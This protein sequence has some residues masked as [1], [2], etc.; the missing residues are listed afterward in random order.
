MSRT[1]VDRRMEA[2][3]FYLEGVGFRGI[4]RLTGI[5]NVTVMR[6]VRALGEKIHEEKTISEQTVA[7]MELDE[8]WHFIAKKNKNVGCGWRMTVMRDESV[9]SNLVAV[10]ILPQKDCGNSLICLI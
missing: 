1:P 8:L 9:P 4:E 3:K 7:I 10:T 5:S 2:I 6:W